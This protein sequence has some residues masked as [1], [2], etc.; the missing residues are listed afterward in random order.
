[1]STQHP[2][3]DAS[4]ARDLLAESFDPVTGELRAPSARE[5]TNRLLAAL[6]HAVLATVAV[7]VVKAVAAVAPPP[8]P[9]SKVYARLDGDPELTRLSADL[10]R[11][12][13]FVPGVNW[14]DAMTA[15]PPAPFAPGDLVSVG[16]EGMPQHP[17][18]VAVVERVESLTEDGWEV[19]AQRADARPVAEFWQ[20]TVHDDGRPVRPLGSGRPVI[21]VT[22]R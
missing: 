10:P 14:Q 13:P 11:P 9:E 19:I 6:A 1:M 7:P 21:T 22:P 2:L 20:A 4:M 5:T 8:E 17:A 3:S 18:V 16:F 12:Q 15:K